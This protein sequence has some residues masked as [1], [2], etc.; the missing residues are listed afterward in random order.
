MVDHAAHG[1]RQGESRARRHEERDEGE[2][3]RSLV[4]QRIG[5]QGPKRR[6]SGFQTAIWFARHGIDGIDVSVLFVIGRGYNVRV[7][8]KR[9]EARVPRPKPPLKRVEIEISF[10]LLNGKNQSNAERYYLSFG[11]M[12]DILSHAQL[13]Q[14]QLVL[15][16]RL[17]RNDA[18]MG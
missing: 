7:R 4:A 10:S 9:I 14:R 16:S 13:T 5:Q 1:E 3:D 17:R 11:Y 8:R 18:P 15:T 12:R 2:H 6:E